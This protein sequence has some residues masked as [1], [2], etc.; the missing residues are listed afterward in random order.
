MKN[1]TYVMCDGILVPSD[2]YPTKKFT[3]QNIYEALR[4][5]DGVILF[6]EDHYQRLQ[7]SLKIAGQLSRLSLDEWK[8]RLMK[9]VSE[10]AQPQINV[11]YDLFYSE[12]G[13]HELIHPYS[14]HYPSESE[15][16]LGVRTELQHDIR[17]NPN[18]KIADPKVREKANE[19]IHHQEVYETLLVD[20]KHCITEGSR[21]NFFAI[22]G[23]TLITAPDQ[24]VLPGIMRSKVIAVAKEMGIAVRFDCIA[25]NELHK[26]EAAFISGTSPRVLPINAIGEFTYSPSHPIINQLKE[27]VEQMV[28]W[29]IYTQSTCKYLNHCPKK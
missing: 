26:I 5:Q 21:S 15:L 22:Q 2:Q 7:N 23:N 17:T 3:G 8:K 13:I 1:H 19:M 12:D 27:G 25:E 29:Y 20:S 11:R 14:S 28:K 6:L 10:N 18:A 24:M 16:K 9:V 4:V